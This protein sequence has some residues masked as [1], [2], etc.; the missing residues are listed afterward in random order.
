MI[1]YQND[2][3]VCKPNSF[4]IINFDAAHSFGTGA[5]DKWNRNWNSDYDASNTDEYSNNFD[6][7]MVAISPNHNGYLNFGV[8]LMVKW[9]DGDG[10]R[11]WTRGNGD[12]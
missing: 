5:I 8:S 7:C 12:G 11:Y 1:T 4:I 2:N 3:F 6:E 9:T 10:T